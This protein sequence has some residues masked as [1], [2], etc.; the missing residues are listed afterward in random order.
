MGSEEQPPG[1][2]T[3]Y[4]MI[5]DT[6]GLADRLRA[7]APELEIEHVIFSGE[8]HLTAGL[9]SLIQGIQFAWPGQR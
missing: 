8:G 1:R 9:L 6:R 2:T 7:G 3:G 4:M 5:D